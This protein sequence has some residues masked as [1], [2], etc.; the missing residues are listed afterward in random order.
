MRSSSPVRFP[1]VFCSSIARMSMVCLAIA[2]STVC[3]SG[4]STSPRCA[5]QAVLID[6]TKVL[7]SI[8]GIEP[9]SSAFVSSLMRRS[10]LGLFAFGS[11]FAFRGLGLGAGAL[12][13][14]GLRVRLDVRQLGEI[15]CVLL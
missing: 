5:M 13:R 1:R 7:K 11:L 3:P 14:H 12:Q 8:G 2:R 4:P 9:S 10:A 6:R 15:L